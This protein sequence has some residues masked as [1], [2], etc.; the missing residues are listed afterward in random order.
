MSE[1]KEVKMEEINT[2]GKFEFRI[3]PMIEHG[4]AFLNRA[5][6]EIQKI[7]VANKAS[8]EGF[9]AEHEEMKGKVTEL[10]AKVTAL[11]QIIGEKNG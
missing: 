6:E 2:E 4:L 5:I 9:I 7:I 11:E 3:K 10:E 8:S 1:Q